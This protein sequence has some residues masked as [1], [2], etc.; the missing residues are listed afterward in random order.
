MAEM[1]KL[2]ADQRTFKAFAAQQ[3]TT[4]RALVRA[5]NSVRDMDLRRHTDH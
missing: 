4:E 3:A 1:E 2:M 5:Y